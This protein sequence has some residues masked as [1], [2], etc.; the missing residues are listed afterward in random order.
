MNMVHFIRII[1]AFSV[2]GLVL[3]KILWK[4][5]TSLTSLI[6]EAKSLT[7]THGR[8]ESEADTIGP[9]GSFGMS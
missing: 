8:K 7:S 3:Y 9:I 2:V 4:K 1:I 6:D 5:E